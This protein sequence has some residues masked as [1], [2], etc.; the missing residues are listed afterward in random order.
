M[1]T[2]VDPPQ[3]RSALTEALAILE[4]WMEAEAHSTAERLARHHAGCVIKAALPDGRLC[5]G[6][7]R[8]IVLAVSPAAANYR[9]SGL[10]LWHETDLQRCPLSGR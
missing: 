1:S 7:R 9:A 8:A 10:V 4:S 3:A 2:M 5:E 6:L